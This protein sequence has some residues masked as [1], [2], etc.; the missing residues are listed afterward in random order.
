MS[1]NEEPWALS[2]PQLLLEPG[3]LHL[4]RAS[5]DLP[6]AARG[7]REAALSTTE[8][9]QCGRL[10]R[11]SDRARCAAARAILRVVLSKYTGES[12]RALS[13]AAGAT[14]KPFLDRATGVRF[15]MSHT[16]ALA[17]IAVARDVEVGV[18]VERLRAVQDME[19]IL[20]NFFSDQERTY[21]YSRGPEDRTRTFF[22]L[23]TRRE[24]AAK[25]M[26][27]GLFD[28]FARLVLPASDLDRSGF[29]L[30]VPRPGARSGGTESWWIRDL[31]PAPGC[32]GALCV[33]ERN[34]DMSFWLFAAP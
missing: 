9:E 26:G 17:L 32:A 33:Q 10:V 21:L 22:R 12:P 29:E 14:G 34:P 23:W 25:A 5:L 19:G 31:V 6:D 4:W 1:P 28:F 18:D 2:P 20:E 27:I 30:A 13:I 11:T 7:P 8:R 16:G 15:N 24:S 3:S